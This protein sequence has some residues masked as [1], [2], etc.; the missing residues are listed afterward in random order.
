MFAIWI[1]CIVRS[2]S[3]HE[4][5]TT[6]VPWSSQAVL[7]LCEKFFGAIMDAFMVRFMIRGNA[8]TTRQQ[9]VNL[10]FHLSSVL[11]VIQTEILSGWTRHA[12]RAAAH[13]HHLTHTL[14]LLSRRWRL[15]LRQMER[16]S[17]FSESIQGRFSL[18]LFESLVVNVFSSFNFDWNHIEAATLESMVRTHIHNRTSCAEGQDQLRFFFMEF[19]RGSAESARRFR[20]RFIYDSFRWWVRIDLRK[21]KRLARASLLE[22]DGAQSIVTLNCPICSCSTLL[23]FVSFSLRF[24]TRAVFVCKAFP[25]FFLLFSSLCLLAVDGARGWIDSWCELKPLFVISEKCWKK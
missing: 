8:S 12:H 18:S 20:F 17:T 22:V 16:A 23:P 5:T 10:M 9:I 4:N 25:Y 13:D 11:N 24:A 15:R 2:R 21:W 14:R 3:K 6:L 19:I 7:H 1:E